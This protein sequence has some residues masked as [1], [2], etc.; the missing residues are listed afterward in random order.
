[1]NL[2]SNTLTGRRPQGHMDMD[3]HGLSVV[4]VEKLAKTIQLPRCPKALLLL[5]SLNLQ[6]LGRSDR[7]FN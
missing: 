7:L 3:Y 1:M 6:R 5:D 4:K 2:N